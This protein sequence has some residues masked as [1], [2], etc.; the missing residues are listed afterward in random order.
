VNVCRK[1]AGQKAIWP[2]E[3]KKSRPRKARKGK[4]GKK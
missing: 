2:R 4:R 1:H 3:T